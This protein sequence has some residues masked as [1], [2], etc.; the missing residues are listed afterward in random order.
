MNEGAIR[1][2]KV[3]VIYLSCIYLINDRD[4][5]V[6]FVYF[7]ENSLTIDISNLNFM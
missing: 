4:A 3:F 7:N 2:D 1:R 5:I 6:V